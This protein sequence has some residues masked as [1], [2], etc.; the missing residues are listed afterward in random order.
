MG[1]LIWT[2]TQT[3]IERHTAVMDSSA[4][5]LIYVSVLVGLSLLYCVFKV[6]GGQITDLFACNVCR[7]PCCDCWGGGGR[8]RAN[9]V[10][11][12]QLGDVGGYARFPSSYLPPMSQ[13]GRQQ[14]PIVIVSKGS[15]DSSS[16]SSSES[17]ESSES[18]DDEEPR[19]GRVPRSYSR[20]DTIRNEERNDGVVVV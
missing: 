7:G 8:V 16:S 11:P 15:G 5:A 17:S 12:V 1:K 13:L 14:P 20:R 10:R 18:S 9:E 19:A 2:V 3:R 4:I 6:F